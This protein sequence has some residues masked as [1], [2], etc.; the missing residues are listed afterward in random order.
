[1]RGTNRTPCWNV[2]TG[3]SRARNLRLLLSSDR[4]YW[5]TQH[6]TTKETRANCG[7]C[8]ET[9]YDREENSR[10]PHEIVVLRHCEIT[11]VV[12]SSYCK[13]SRCG[14]LPAAAQLRL[15]GV[16]CVVMGWRR[17][18]HTLCGK[19]M[20]S[21]FKMQIIRSSRGPTQRMQVPVET[22]TANTIL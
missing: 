12:A 11:I 13:C 1:M 14:E 22:Q 2:R 15:V 9:H 5:H 16:P 20:T 7:S 3:V 8:N 21:T 18:S 6:Q 17:T 19:V 4:T 10:C